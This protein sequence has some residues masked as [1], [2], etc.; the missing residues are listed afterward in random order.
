MINTRSAQRGF[1]LLEVLIALALMATLAIL[2]WRALDTTARSSERL[3][4][5]A[6]DTLTILRT[7]GQIETDLGRH[8]GRDV[9]PIAPLP[10]DPKTQ[11]SVVGS[12]AQPSVVGTETQPSGAGTQA[13]PPGIRWTPNGLVLLRSTQDGGWQ[14]VVWTLTDNILWRA[15]G[16]PGRHLPLPVATMADPMLNNVHGFTVR[17][18]LPGRGWADASAAQAGMTATGLEIAVLREHEGVAETY[19]KVVLLP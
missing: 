17:A 10:D 16:I 3:A 7:L 15:A 4:A 14:Q 9:F 6:D 11:P 19:R 18:W 12:G 2:S 8:A 13:L 1:T 5:S